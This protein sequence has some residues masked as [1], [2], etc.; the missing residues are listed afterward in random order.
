[1]HTVLGGT[2]QFDAKITKISSNEIKISYRVWD[3]FGAGTDDAK[4]NLPGLPSMYWL[5]H[6]TKSKYVPFI[7]NINVNR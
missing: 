4:S 5:Q 7:W 6:N 2:Q 1:M 3:H